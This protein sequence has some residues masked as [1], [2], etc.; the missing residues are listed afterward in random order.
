M[1]WMLPLLVAACDGGGGSG[2]SYG[3]VPPRTQTAALD[4]VLAALSATDS[5]TAAVD[6]SLSGAWSGGATG[7]VVA[8]TGVA[9]FARSMASVQVSFP[10]AP[11]SGTP[12]LSHEILYYPKA[13]YLGTS[14]SVQAGAGAGGTAGGVA[15]APAIYT[16]VSATAKEYERVVTGSFA[17]ALQAGLCDPRF[18]LDEVSWGVVRGAVAPGPAGSEG[19]GASGGGGESFA[20]VVNF[21]RAADEAA[22]P[23]KALAAATAEAMRRNVLGDVPTFS[24]DVVVNTS[25]RVVEIALE[26]PGGAAP[27]AGSVSETLSSFGSA[28]DVP[29]APAFNVTGITAVLNSS[30][31]I[32]GKEGPG[33]FDAS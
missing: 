13:Y 32:G 19:T 3:P 10:Q 1:V 20:V 31:S 5:S 14:S 11:R 28:V 23:E 30:G 22:G 16:W 8:G 24:A 15:G 9:D 2:G 27:S 33:D 26:S 7:G 12:P 6:M 29:S 17:I 18:L 21:H 4:K 25:G